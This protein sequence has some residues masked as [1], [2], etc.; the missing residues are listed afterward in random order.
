MSIDIG[1]RTAW[2]SLPANW[3]VHV[4]SEVNGFQV[5]IRDA[6]G[7][8]PRYMPSPLPA[9]PARL[10]E[11]SAAWLRHVWTSRQRSILWLL[12]LDVGL[13]TWRAFLPSQM[14]SRTDVRFDPRSVAAE[15]P[16]PAL[17]V[18][19]SLFSCPLDGRDDLLTRVP[20]F[21]GL[22]LAM[23]PDRGW[24][25]LQAFVVCGGVTQPLPEEASVIAED[26]SR[27]PVTRLA[28][29]QWLVDEL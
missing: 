7:V 23:R 2:P 6:D 27:L 26:H 28:G 8:D 16:A 12:Y 24:L 9:L 20:P 3:G 25:H 21:D 22:H 19:G 5:T 1:D 17:R 11:D 14:C 10:L 15:N 13:G 4:T 29:R 18:A